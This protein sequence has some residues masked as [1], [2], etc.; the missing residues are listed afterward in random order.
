[1][2]VAVRGVQGRLSPERDPLGL[3]CSGA[4][5][6]PKVTALLVAGVPADPE[7]D[8]SQ[9]FAGPGPVES[10][11]RKVCA[12]ARETVK[13]LRHQEGTRL[14][15]LAPVRTADTGHIPDRPSL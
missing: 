4:P 11:H 8:H 10:C 2:P 7:C 6:N 14:R 9:P 3:T 13:S 12:S 5:P 15:E 1:M